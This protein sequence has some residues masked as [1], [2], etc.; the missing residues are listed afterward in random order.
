MTD[1]NS[2]LANTVTTISCKFRCTK[3]SSLSRQSAHD[4]RATTSR[5]LAQVRYLARLCDCAT[6]RAKSCMTTPSYKNDYTFMQITSQDPAG[7]DQYAIP[8]VRG[9]RLW[10]YLSRP[11]DPVPGL[12]WGFWS[13]DQSSGRRFPS[14]HGTIVYRRCRRDHNVEQSQRVLL[15]AIRV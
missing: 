8:P 5:Q 13:A 9:D 4:V 6:K 7:S 11:V 12:A 15:R 10:H 3:L 2:A 1:V 14:L